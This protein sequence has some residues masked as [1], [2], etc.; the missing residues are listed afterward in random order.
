M[1]AQVISFHC[2]IKNKSGHVISTTFNQDVVTAHAE[3][4]KNML[5]GLAEGLQDLHQGEKRRISVSA[6]RA[7]GFYDPSKVVVCSVDC[8]EG[9]PV[10][11]GESLMCMFRG[12]PT[13][14]RLIGRQ[15]GQVTLDANHPLAGQ[16]LVFEI[17]AV[18]VREALPEEI[19]G[20]ITA[21]MTRLH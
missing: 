17:E 11:I 2:I 9:E 6:E 3:P 10:V 5:P 13:Q 1:K 14:F 7:Y 16:D 18:D 4:E 12:T 21:E 19:P 15:G 20:V 8:L